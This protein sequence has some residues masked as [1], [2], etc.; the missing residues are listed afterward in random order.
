MRNNLVPLKAE[1][2]V[3]RVTRR[4]LPIRVELDKRG[5]DLN[6]VRC[7]LCDDNI[8]SLDHVFIFCKHALDVW[9]RVYKWW[10]VGSVTNLSIEEAFRGNIS[11]QLSSLGIKLWQSVEW[12][13]AYLIWW[14]RNQKVFSNKSWEGPNAL[15]EIQLKSYKW[16]SKRLKRK[17]IDWIDWLTNPSSC[18]S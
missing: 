8:E 1:V 5:I 13:C 12:T 17:R 4:R 18:G 10:G 3:W 7:P 16:I 6:S 14:N 11:G 9:E 15:L 2:F